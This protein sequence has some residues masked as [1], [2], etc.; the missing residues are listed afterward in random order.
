[1]TAR[2]GRPANFAS[3]AERVAPAVRRLSPL[4]FAYTDQRGQRVK[5]D[6]TDSPMPALARLLIGA[7]EREFD[8]DGRC[9]SAGAATTRPTAVRRF[10]AELERAGTGDLGPEHLS[11]E[12][13]GAFESAIEGTASSNTAWRKVALI[14]GL[15]R[16]AHAADLFTPSAGLE[17]RLRYNTMRFE[18][19]HHPLDSYPAPVV[20][21]LR[22]AAWADLLAAR[23]R[24]EQGEAVLAG[25]D[26]DDV[27]LGGLVRAVHGRGGY[28]TGAQAAALRLR[29]A[30]DQLGDASRLLHITTDELAAAL[31]LLGIKTGIEPESLVELDRRCVPDRPDAGS[32]PLAYIKRRAHASPN[33]VASVRDGPL[34][35]PGGLLRLVA[36]LT[37]HS[38]AVLGT[39]RLFA[40][41]G[42]RGPIIAGPGPTLN[43]A[44]RRFMARHE[45]IAPDGTRVATIDRRRLRKSHK[46]DRYLSLGGV[47]SDFADGHSAE[48][49]GRHYADIPSLR[50]LHEAT[51]E[52]AL[53][54]ALAVARPR[55]LPTAEL[56]RLAAGPPEPANRLGQ[57]V[58][59]RIVSG[60]ADVFVASCTDITHS[61]FGAPGPVCPSP[62]SGCF[63]CP[64][65][66]FTARRLPAVIAYQHHCEAEAKR[67]PATEWQR[68]YGEAYRVIVDEILPAM[69]DEE[70]AL[71]S[72]QAGTAFVPAEARR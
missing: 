19:R 13:L 57:D 63:S 24:R 49:A 23:R 42:A 72:A 20:D 32:V 54:D 59:A 61:P 67:W 48:V 22:R 7:M 43:F 58:A 44:L 34:N 45:V 60:E 9:R 65:A 56:A 4:V 64:N 71:A 26:G 68:R 11:P 28:L 12:H 62:F 31:V 37:A 30:H 52:Q 47:L 27:V 29:G 6:L 25:Q 40:C 70:V 50:H 17:E 35:T 10:L 14:C 41:L 5:L 51:V 8:F 18:V 15:L 36:Q 2:R 55:V 21:Q 39:D 46:R 1:M 33:R 53:G 3:P 66:V 16:T 69:T 38:A